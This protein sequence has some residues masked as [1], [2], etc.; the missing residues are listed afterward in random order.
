MQIYIVQ[1]AATYF[2]SKFSIQRLPQLVGFTFYPFFG[3]FT[4]LHLHR[5]VTS[6]EENFT[7]RHTHTHTHIHTH[8]Y[9]HIKYIYK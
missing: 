9:T 3:L 7:P 4:A 5:N 1:K 8:T 6:K 2:D